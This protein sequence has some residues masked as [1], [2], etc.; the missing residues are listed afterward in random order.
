[1]GR[2]WRAEG[3]LD[4]LLCGVERWLVSLASTVLPFPRSYVAG[5]GFRDVFRFLLLVA[6]VAM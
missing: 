2:G 4:V 1:M 3:G 6:A 5:S